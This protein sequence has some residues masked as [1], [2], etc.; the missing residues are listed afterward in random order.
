MMDYNA[1]YD[2]KIVS[3][4]E[5]KRNRQNV[6]DNWMLGP[7]KTSVDPKANKAYSCP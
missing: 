3:A 5:N 1:I 4:A 6:M 2:R 7:E